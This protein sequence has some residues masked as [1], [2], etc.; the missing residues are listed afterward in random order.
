MIA[1]D[2]KR[3]NYGGADRK[4]RVKHHRLGTSAHNSVMIETW[5][6]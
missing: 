6:L 2:S 1:G 5:V 4:V 3:T